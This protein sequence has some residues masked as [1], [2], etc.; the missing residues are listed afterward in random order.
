MTRTRISL[1][2][3]ALTVTA[4]TAAIAHDTWLLPSS[5]VVPVGRTVTLDLTSGSAFPAPG[6]AIKPARVVEARA[7]MGGEAA[8]LAAPTTGAHALVYRWTPRAAG[9]ANLWIRLAPLELEL[10]PAQA[11]GY[12]KEVNASA[13][14][15]AAW[16]SVPQP[17]RWRESYAK[18]SK[19][20]IRVGNPPAGDSSWAVPVGSGLEIVPMRDPT[21]L[22][23]GD[24]LAI[25]VLRDGA[26]V[27]AFPVAAARAGQ[28]D[29][30]FAYT[31][32]SGVARVP[33]PAAGLW[34]LRG[35]QLRREHT[36]NLE[37]RS[38]FTTATLAV[39]GAEG[40]QR[41]PARVNGR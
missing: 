21:A 38:D 7:R 1:V 15:R 40:H 24:T 14:V 28:A 10:T 4:A 6:S 22:T 3:A 5:L 41:A 31:D 8:A 32:A 16:D 13:E 20:F 30:P 37:W 27:P 34:M 17:R 18:L 12:M 11:E 36:A 9:V 2:V 23:A 19:T 29:A 35:T 26:P 39:R 33:L 25:R